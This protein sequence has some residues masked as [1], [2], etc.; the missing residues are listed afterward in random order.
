MKDSFDNFFIYKNDRNIVALHLVK[1][2]LEAAKKSALQDERRMQ[3]KEIG[4]NWT[5]IYELSDDTLHMNA[6]SVDRA[7]NAFIQYLVN[8]NYNNFDSWEDC[9]EEADLYIE[10]L[11]NLVEKNPFIEAQDY[12]TFGMRE[13]G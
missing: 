5:K 1:E 12:F 2:S 6:L 3:Y 10:H 4:G 9:M 13:G 7:L 8:E 11:K